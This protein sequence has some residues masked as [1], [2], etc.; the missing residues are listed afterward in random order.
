MS[1]IKS[2]QDWLEQ[3][4]GMELLTDQTEEFPSSYALAPSGNNTTSIDILGKR[5]YQNSYVFYAKESASAEIDRQDTYDFLEGLSLWLEDQADRDDLPQ[6]PGYRVESLEVSN[7]FLAEIDENGTGLY[8]V[9][10]QIIISKE[11]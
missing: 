3:Y 9:Q 1:M 11:Q 6:L 7:A 10:I 5:T 4:K 8:Q 2:I